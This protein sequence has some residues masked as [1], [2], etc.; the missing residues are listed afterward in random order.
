MNTISENKFKYFYF[1]SF[2]L[3]TIICL[4][5]FDQNNFWIVK[6]IVG[7]KGHL[8][9][10]NPDVAAY[11][12]MVKYFR[13]EITLENSEILKPFSYRIVPTFLASLLPYKALTSL[14]VVNMIF[15]YLSLFYL[16]K[17]FKKLKININSQFISTGLFIFSFPM[18][19]YG[20][21]GVIDP[22]LISFLTIGIYLI[23]ND[24]YRSIVV[25]TYISAMVKETAIILIPFYYFYN[26][27]KKLN[28]I[29][30]SVLFFAFITSTFFYA[31][32][33]IQ[34]PDVHNFTPS[35]DFVKDNLYRPRAYI[36]YVLSYIYLL[37]LVYLGIRKIEKSNL[38]LSL[39]VGLIL[40]NGIY[41]YSFIAA[42]PDGRLIWPAYPFT[43]VLIGLYLNKFYSK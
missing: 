6:K 39:I 43:I 38:K 20:S 12:D 29:K 21:S 41:A 14:N 17:I 36:T 8:G 31:R 19:Y 4:P 11:I 40:G 9:E 22:V 16:F 27:S 28:F 3:L 33:V 18:F 24:K 7:N 35:W 15:N 30:T 26:K 37:P 25:L 5:R 23:L 10:Y 32:E 34:L 1:L 13:S 42:Y 2:I